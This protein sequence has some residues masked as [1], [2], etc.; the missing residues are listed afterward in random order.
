MLWHPSECRDNRGKNGRPSEAIVFRI[1][2][3][4]ER[5]TLFITGQ[6]TNSGNRLERIVIQY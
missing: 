2:G 3:K 1:F 6:A 4:E 5:A